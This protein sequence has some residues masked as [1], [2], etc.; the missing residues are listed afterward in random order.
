MRFYLLSS[1][2]LLSILAVAQPATD[3]RLKNLDSFASKVLKDWHTAGVAIAVVEKGKVIYA[4]GFGYRDYEK[5]LPVTDKTLFAIG[6][7]TKAFTASL[8][9][10][11]EKE[12]KLEIEKPVINYLPQLKFYNEYTTQ[13]VT[14]QDLMCHRTGLPRH[15]FS[16][17]AF[18]TTRDSLIKRIGFLEPSYELRLKYQYNNFMFLLQGVLAE[19]LTGKTWEQNVQERFFKPLGMTA[20]NFSIADMKKSVDAAKGYTEKKDS[21]V[22]MDYYNIDAMGPAGAINS[23]AAEMANWV[24]TWIQNGKFNGKEII[25]AA[26]VAQAKSA[27]MVS[28]S[29][30]P[31]AQVPDAHFSSYGYGWGL[32]SYRGHYRVSHGGNIDGFSASATFFPTD[33]IGI[34]VLVNQ[35]GS[36]VP[37][38]IRNFIADKLLKLPAKDWNSM[39][40]VQVFNQRVAAAKTKNSDSLLRKSG[41]HPTQNLKNYAG[42]YNHPGYGKINIEYRND[43]LI[44]SSSILKLWLQHYHYDVFRPMAAAAS[45]DLPDNNTM[46]FQFLSNALGEIDR[47]SIAG[48]EPSVKELVF[49]KEPAAINLTKE[50]LEKYTGEYSLS[51]SPVKIFIKEGKTLV[52]FLQGQPEYELVPQGN[53]KFNLKALSGYSVQFKADDKGKITGLS[54][55]QPNG[56]FTATKK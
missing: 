5:K 47:I 1:L 48:F 34:V 42:V 8:L 37:G 53:H 52:A 55:I 39:S 17:Y 35:N 32:N 16:W 49:T 24:I 15:D 19:K 4:G 25:P 50:E 18:P 6:S 44:A 23:N 26:Y 9:G 27:Q 40:R 45:I 31:D 46:R 51:G 41:T 56:V 54:F 43:S 22:A 38:I 20:S 21:I 12:G 3:A 28:G 13:H 2:L 14:V 10:V 33:S 36:A 11:L 29:G 7:C 30:L